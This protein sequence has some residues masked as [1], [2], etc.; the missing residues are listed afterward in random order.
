MHPRL[1]PILKETCGVVL[2]QEQVMQIVQVRAG[3]TLG[4]VFRSMT[5]QVFFMLW[6][7]KV[8]SQAW[9]QIKDRSSA[10]TL[11]TVLVR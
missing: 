1:E 3:F 4:Q 5:G 2:Y 9:R 6:S 10:S 11:S 8:K 7:K